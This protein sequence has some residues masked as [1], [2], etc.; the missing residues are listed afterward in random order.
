MEKIQQQPNDLGVSLGE[1]L[2]GFLP[3]LHYVL[4]IMN[5]LK[6]ALA[7]SVPVTV[8][9]EITRMW[10]LLLMFIQSL[11]PSYTPDGKWNS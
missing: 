7:W 2:S 4:S 1:V 3:A 8:T 5:S 6:Q 11:S 10:L 9:A